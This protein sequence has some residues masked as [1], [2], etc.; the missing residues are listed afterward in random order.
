MNETSER[1][2]ITREEVRPGLTME[3][4]RIR[5]ADGRYLIYYEFRS[6]GGGPTAGAD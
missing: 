1:D 4:R 3:K 5:K 6:H 2:E